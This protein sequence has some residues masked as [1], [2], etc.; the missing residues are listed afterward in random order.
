MGNVSIPRYSDL[1]DREEQRGRLTEVQKAF[2]ALA[3]EAL[4]GGADV[5][6]LLRSPV[7]LQCELALGE[8]R[9]LLNLNF[10]SIK[11]LHTY[12]IS[13]RIF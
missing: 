8:K 3:L 5:A 4:A 11:L 2:N 10:K 9:D 7:E 6:N 13:L 1:L 12:P